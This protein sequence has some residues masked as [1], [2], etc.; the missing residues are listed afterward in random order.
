VAMRLSTLVFLDSSDI[1]TSISVTVVI[2]QLLIEATLVRRADTAAAGTV[3]LP[4]CRLGNSLQRLQLISDI[5]GYSKS[6][7]CLTELQYQIRRSSSPRSV[8]T[9]VSPIT[10]ESLQ[11]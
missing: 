3:M 8:P 11:S 1:L 9:H 7:L 5:K 2:P 6:D 4:K 10:Q